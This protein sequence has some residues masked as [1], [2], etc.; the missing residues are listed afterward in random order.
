M[1]PVMLIFGS[2]FL[3]VE[4]RNCNFIW[5]VNLSNWSY[6]DST[7]NKSARAISKYSVNVEKEG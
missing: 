3:Q 5:G 4:R 1:G 6:I 2:N 7:W